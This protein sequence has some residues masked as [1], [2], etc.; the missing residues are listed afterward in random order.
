MTYL[1]YACLIVQPTLFVPLAS[2]DKSGTMRCRDSRI[3]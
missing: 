2:L 1:L 3:V